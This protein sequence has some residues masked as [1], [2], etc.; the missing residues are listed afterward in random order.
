MNS[1]VHAFLL[2]SCFLVT[3]EVN[4]YGESTRLLIQARFS[5]PPEDGGILTI[6]VAV[7]III[8]FKQ[9]LMKLRLALDLQ[10]SQGWSRRQDP[11]TSASQ[12]LRLCKLH[13]T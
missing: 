12:I 9:G 10:C 5:F 3:S 7:V 8:N 2:P 13:H 1:K 4:V 6:V 11:M